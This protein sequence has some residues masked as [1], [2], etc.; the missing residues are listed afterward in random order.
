MLRKRVSK[1]VLQ[2]RGAVRCSGGVRHKARK[3]YSGAELAFV[4]RVESILD[5]DYFL[6]ANVELGRISHGLPILT[7][8]TGG[9]VR[10]TIDP[11]GQTMSLVLGVYDNEFSAFGSMLKDFVRNIVFPSIAPYVPSSS[12]QGAEA[13]LRTIKKP[14][15]GL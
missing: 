15:G 11:S 3:D 14:R 4:Y 13:F 8:E 1:S 7:K 12:R 5:G 2:N 6:K 9:R 10:V